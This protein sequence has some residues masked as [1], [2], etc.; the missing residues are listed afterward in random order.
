MCSLPHHASQAPTSLAMASEKCLLL[1]EGTVWLL[2]QKRV[3]AVS[4][5]GR[6]ADGGGVSGT[7]G[8]GAD[9]FGGT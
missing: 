8:L 2:V 3:S 9:G 1:A 4:G 7:G 5:G 6:E